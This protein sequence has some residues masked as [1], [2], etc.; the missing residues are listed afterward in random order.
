MGNELNCLSP[1]VCRYFSTVEYVLSGDVPQDDRPLESFLQL[2][3]VVNGCTTCMYSIVKVAMSQRSRI[4]G[5]WISDG[6]EAIGHRS[7]GIGVLKEHTVD[8]IQYPRFSVPRNL[9]DP[10]VFLHA[11]WT[12]SNLSSRTQSPLARSCKNLRVKRKSPSGRLASSLAT[13]SS[14]MRTFRASRRARACMPSG[15]S[16]FPKSSGSYSSTL[17]V[18]KSRG[19]VNLELDFGVVKNHD[20]LV[21]WK[22]HWRRPW[23]SRWKNC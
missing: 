2:C 15:I 11:A 4:G 23:S 5:I 10:L 21:G 7:D 17:S 6:V 16:T 13:Y 8:S 19:A 22:P 14:A 3:H 9:D 18:E 20:P 1:T 12:G